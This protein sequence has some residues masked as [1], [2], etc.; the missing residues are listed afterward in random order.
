MLDFL[1]YAI[2]A[3][4]SETTGGAAF[5]NIIKMV[6]DRGRSFYRLFHSPS[7][8]I[9]KGTKILKSQKKI[10]GAGMVM[11][12]I[13][14]EANSEISKQMQVLSLTEGAFL[15]HLQSALLY[16]GKDLRVSFSNI[17]A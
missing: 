14:E 12:A 3:P 9:V 6:S 8:T 4:Y 10:L 11:R 7:M 1:T 17:A 5:D 2:C 15:S 16:K 13:I